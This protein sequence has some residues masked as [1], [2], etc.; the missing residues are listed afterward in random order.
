MTENKYKV[1]ARQWKKWGPLQQLMFNNMNEFMLSNQ[2]IISH[3]KAP[4]LP[5]D[6]WSTIAWN[7]AWHAASS[8]SSLDE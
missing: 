1:P 3:P 2:K 4:R 7:A 5:D 6:Q 8:M